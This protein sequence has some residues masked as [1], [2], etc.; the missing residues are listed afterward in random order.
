MKTPLTV[1]L[2]NADMLE[3]QI[4]SENDTQAARWIENIHVEG[5]RMRRLVESMLFLARSDAPSR[6]HQGSAWIGAMQSKVVY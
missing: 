1:I 4:M 6:P 5:T 2:S 3:R